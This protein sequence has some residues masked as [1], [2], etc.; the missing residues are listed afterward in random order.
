MKFDAF[1]PPDGIVDVI[2]DT[3]TFNE[4]DDQFAVAYM[5]RSPEKFNIKGICAAPF[6]NSRST[7]PADGME[8]SYNEILKL[9]QLA[10]CRELEGKVYRGS[11]NYLSDEH[12]AVDSAAAR[13]IAETAKNYTREKPLYIVAIG[14][15]TNV[16]SALLAYPEIKDRCVIVWLGGNA[17]HMP[18]N[19]E[20]NLMQDIAAA[21]VVFGCGAPVVQLPCTGVV[22]HLT[23]TRWELEHWLGGE[24]E[25][26]DYLVKATVDEAESYAAGKP[27]SRVIWDI[28]TI[29]WF[30]NGDGHMMKSRMISAPVPGYDNKYEQGC[31]EHEMCYVYHIDRDAIFEHLFGK[32]G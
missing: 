18:D 14:A 8:R 28:S 27:W 9:L 5:L 13:F 10:G 29:A 4:I 30:F 19:R 23:T 3:D 32:L 6:F 1:A 15:I 24:S 17:L 7:S 25:L 26:C 12:T 22:D 11:E 21:R 2:L 16:A 20:F 31:F